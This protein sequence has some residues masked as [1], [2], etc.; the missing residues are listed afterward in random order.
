MFLGGRG[1]GFSVIGFYLLVLDVQ[2]FILQRNVQE[3]RLYGFQGLIMVFIIFGKSSW[4]G[5][6][7]FGG[8]RDG[9]VSLFLDQREFVV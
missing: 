3:I 2:D 8:V 5:K 9:V 4:V 1:L 7:R 6:S